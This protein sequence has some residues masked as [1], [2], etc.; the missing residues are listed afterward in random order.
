MTK[1]ILFHTNVVDLSGYADDPVEILMSVQLGGGT[2]INGALSYCERLVE[3]PYR[4][5]IVLVS[6]LFEGCGYENMYRVS[7]GIIESGV[8]LVA[9]TALD[10]DA[11][12][13]YDRN[14][15]KR[16]AEMG[17]HVGAMTPEELVEFVS[18]V[19]V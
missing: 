9:L 6:D 8:K 7:N 3:Y 14:A 17:A 11:N 2:D 15:A 13:D 16:L 18:K 4:T 5:M 19:V 1:R 12:P 10:M